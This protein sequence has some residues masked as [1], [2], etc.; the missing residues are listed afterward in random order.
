MSQTTKSEFSFNVFYYVEWYFSYVRFGFFSS[1]LSDW[2]VKRLQN[3][4]LFVE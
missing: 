1:M 2:L 4:L 3:V